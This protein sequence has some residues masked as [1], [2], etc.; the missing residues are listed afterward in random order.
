MI[1]AKIEVADALGATTRQH[2]A[3][4]P[5]RHNSGMSYQHPFLDRVALSASTS[6]CP[7]CRYLFRGRISFWPTGDKMRFNKS[8]IF[9]LALPVPVIILACL[10]G[11]WLT[12]PGMIAGSAVDAA[13]QSALQTARQFK[14][15]R[16]Y[17][18]KNIIKKAKANGS[19]KPSI[20]HAKRPDGIPLPATLIHD[21]SKLLAKENTT[22]SLYSAFPFPNR[23][24]RVMDEFMQ[25][26]WAFLS[27]NPD[28][29]FKQLVTHNGKSVLRVAIA[30][31]MAAD[32]CVNCHNAHPQ[33]PKNDWKLGDVR[34]VLE[35]DSNV[36]HVLLAASDLNN[37]IIAGIFV[38]GL[39]LL[40]VVVFGARA[41]SRPI[42]QMTTSM[43]HIADDDLTTDVPHLDRS[44]EVGH[45]AGALQVFKEKA[46]RNK[47]LEAEQAEHDQRLAEGQEKQKQKDDAAAAERNL[48]TRSFSNAMS[49]IAKKDLS[50]RIVEEFPAAYQDLKDDFNRTFEQLAETINHIRT[51]S[52]QIMAGSQEINTA[53]DN[54][55][56]R[57]EQQAETVAETATAVEE[58]TSTVTSSADRA[59]DA[60]KLVAA[61]RTNAQGASN[62]VREAVSAM[63]KIE[64]SAGEIASITDVI[65]E[66]A[67]QTNLLALNAGVE[68]A[69]AGDAGAGFAVVAQEVRGLAQRSAEAAK[70]I[71]QL[72]DASGAD[73]KTGSSL[74][75]DTGRALEAI[76]SEVTEING[77]VDAISAAASEQSTGLQEINQS[78]NQID[79]GTQQN[80]AVAE[81][82]LA[83]SRCLSEEVAKID[84]MLAEFN[85]IGDGSGQVFQ[86]AS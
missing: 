78:V 83:A 59:N 80:A 42:N 49:S 30:D 19:L 33:T 17:Y 7:D 41:V 53:S 82:T 69:R 38:A 48:V 85:T 56:R 27:K 76:V 70:E 23:K 40:V 12:I 75:S 37:Q 66:I 26:A 81:E 84:Q 10:V 35:I 63:G 28:Q 21:L 55:A 24:D 11:A 14:V 77:H 9:K 65:D 86:Q 62:V 47:E 2:E 15:I 22:M 16:G 25:N 32:A 68:A 57:T 74:V 34:G 36:D 73:V 39:V 54:L 79:Q 3:L 29:T 50:Y 4:Q 31:R 8:I 43:R 18:T 5:R 72:I 58:T 61:S 6:W 13:T 52:A 64:N 45:M 71:K 20:D 44:D 51:A 46:V 60:A 1:L 67:F